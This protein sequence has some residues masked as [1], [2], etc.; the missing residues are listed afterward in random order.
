MDR[1]RRRKYTFGLAGVVILMWGAVWSVAQNQ[2]ATPSIFALQQVIGKPQPHDMRYNPQYDRF[3]WINAAGRL[4]LA[5]ATS[6]EEIAVLTPDDPGTRLNDYRFSPDGRWLAVARD[7]QI[8]L[9]DVQTAALV[10]NF[11]TDS[12]LGLEGPL[13]FSD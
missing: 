4:A 1:G 13:W 11:Q 2:P 8:D 7:K 9:W 12:T 6:Y 5:D 3:A 10:A